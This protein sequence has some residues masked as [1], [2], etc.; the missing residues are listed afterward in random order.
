M[1]ASTD[2]N[3]LALTAD[4]VAAYVSR[5]MTQTND[6]PALIISVN[7]SLKTVE[8]PQT[9]TADELTP[10]VPIKKSITPD[11]MICLEDGKRLKMLKRHLRTSYQMTPDEYRT[12]WGLPSDYPMVAPNYSK[13]RSDTAHKIGLGKRR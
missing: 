10:A 5:N 3:L 1:A 13:V 4:I 11:F 9:G 12:K 8:E 2:N 6:L 7:Q